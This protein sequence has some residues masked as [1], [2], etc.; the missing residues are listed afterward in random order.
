MECVLI[1]FKYNALIGL[2]S[3]APQCVVK[4]YSQFSTALLS[5]A[6]SVTDLEPLVK[7]PKPTAMTDVTKW[8]R[9]LLY[10]Y[11]INN[12]IYTLHSALTKQTMFDPIASGLS[13]C[14]L[15]TVD[16]NIFEILNPFVY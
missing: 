6:Q 15:L 11:Y 14:T 8:K 3:S 12:K 7:E 1:C 9:I 5:S 16:I 4:S 10:K 13:D 2:L